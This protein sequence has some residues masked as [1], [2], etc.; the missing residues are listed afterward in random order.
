MGKEEQSDKSLKTEVVIIGASAAGLALAACLK[1]FKIPFIILERADHVAPAWRKHYERLHLHTDK[2]NSKLPYMG[3]P[4]HYLKYPSRLQVIEYLETYARHFQ[5]EPAFGQ[6][7]FSAER[8]NGVWNTKT[9]D[10]TYHSKYIVI[11]SGFTRDPNIPTL[12]GEKLFGGTIMHS[13]Q[14]RNGEQFKGQEVLV[15]GF[16]NSGGEIAI[17]L[18]ESGAKPSISV[19]SPVNVIPRDLLGLPILAIEI[20]LSKLPPR[21][22]DFLSAPLLRLT[23]GDLTRFGLPRPPY[24]AVTQITR[25][26]KVPLLDIGTVRL[27]KQGHINV[28]PGVETFTKEGVRFS[29]G[30]ER[31]FATVILATGY[32]PNVASYL[33]DAAV[34]NSNGAPST[35][36]RETSP[37]LYFCGFYVAPTGMLREIAI[38]AKK[39]SRDIKRKIDQIKGE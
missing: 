9:E 1:K 22:I 26:G 20:A 15:V 10:A 13:S 5:I 4:K 24:G 39:I 8:L 34:I 31:N 38:E 6:E 36:G 7:V 16:G 23:M 21:V 29:N 25:I 33:K 28:L 12:R 30:E 18:F 37:G 2:A 17:D 35:S 3:F 19:R 27:I 32:R 11:A 14:F